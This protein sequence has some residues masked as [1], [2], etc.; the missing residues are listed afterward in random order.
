[1]SPVALAAGGQQGNDGGAPLLDR[2]AAQ[3]DPGVDRRSSRVLVR[4]AR[5]SEIPALAALVDAAFDE[6]RRQRPQAVWARHI[7]EARDL[8]RRWETSTVLVAEADGELA[9]SVSF[10][11]EAARAGMGLPAGWA[12][13]RNLAVHPAHRGRGLGRALALDCIARARAA[14]VA[15]VAIHTSARM[16]A[17]NGLYRALGFRR[18]PE[19]DADATALLGFAGEAAVPLIAFRLDL[20]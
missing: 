19:H 1:M 13:F 5:R 18:C 17:A 16:T 3:G 14:G 9:G 6:F 15:T 7:A 8:A 20:D 4:P 11:A 2:G 12:G 10:Y